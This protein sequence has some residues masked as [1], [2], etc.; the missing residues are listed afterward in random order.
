MP[1]EKGFV[2][3]NQWFFSFASPKFWHFWSCLPWNSHFSWLRDD[4]PTSTIAIP[5]LHSLLSDTHQMW[6]GLLDSGLYENYKMML[7]A[8]GL[9]SWNQ[10]FMPCCYL[11]KSGINIYNKMKKVCCRV[12]VPTFSCFSQEIWWETSSFVTKEISGVGS[13]CDYYSYR[14]W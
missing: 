10:D 12:L 9:T 7:R 1:P 4:T 13:V 11:A 5:F 6:R 2:I 8:T 14:F 3:I